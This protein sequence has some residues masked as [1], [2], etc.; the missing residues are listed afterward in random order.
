MN[1]KQVGLFFY[2]NGKFLLHYC[3]LKDA[4]NYGNFLIYSDSHFDIW[5]KYYYSKFHVDFDFFPRGRIAYHKSNNTFLIYY[6]KCIKHNID[7]ILNKYI[8]CNTELS[9]DEH[10]QCHKCN[11]NYIL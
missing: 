4:E 8:G 2:V 7:E 1:E 5:E 3:D 9:L 6:D 11:K 10:Y